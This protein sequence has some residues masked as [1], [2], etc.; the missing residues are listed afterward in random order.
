[1]LQCED[2]PR[3][4]VS[5][6]P[7]AAVAASRVHLTRTATYSYSHGAAER[8]GL[9]PG[10]RHVRNARATQDDKNKKRV[11]TAQ[12]SEGWGAAA[13]SAAPTPNA[14]V[15]DASFAPHPLALP[16]SLAHVSMYAMPTERMASWLE[17]L[18]RNSPQPASFCAPPSGV[19]AAGS[20]VLPMAPVSASAG[21]ASS[22]RRAGAADWP[23]E[24]PSGQSLSLW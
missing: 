14:R 19:S 15:P 3:G 8:E 24:R 18:C 12:T 1:M 9:T 7:A 4:R 11:C 6:S 2:Q 16:L 23:R 10:A 13:P 22:P 20:A 5:Q 21:R 17:L